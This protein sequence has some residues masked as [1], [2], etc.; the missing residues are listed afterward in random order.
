MHSLPANRTNFMG[1]PEWIELPWKGRTKSLA[2]RFMDVFIHGLSILE[3]AQYIGDLKTPA[4]L[5]RCLKVIDSCWK[6][7]AAMR[8][9]YKE[10][11]DSVPGP[12]FWPE[13][14]THDNPA[15]DAEMGK[16]F[17]VAFHFVNLRIARICGL[18]WAICI[19]LWGGLFHLYQ[20][21]AFMEPLS[22]S[23]SSSDTDT[24]E[25]CECTTSFHLCG[26]GFNISDLPLLQDRDV[27]TAVTNICQSFEYCVLPENRL[28][29]AASIA[30]PLQVV[31]GTLKEYPGREREM[32]WVRGALEMIDE[33]GFRILKFAKQ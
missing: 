21:I 10:L 22:P 18:Y 25:D 30:F 3:A 29:G 26:R 19:I 20:A 31:L 32:G 23:P 11:K 5:L 15:D 7:D 24:D 12:L 8:A 27:M 4:S 1:D 9:L 28:L 6:S 14:S 16:V 17:P 2:D 13:L 33:K